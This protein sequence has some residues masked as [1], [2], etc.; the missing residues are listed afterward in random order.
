[1]TCCDC[2][3]ASYINISQIYVVFF[4]H[5]ISQL[6][7]KDTWAWKHI[8]TIRGKIKEFEEKFALA[9]KEENSKLEF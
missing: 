2:I 7:T 9:I 4:T 8:L 1:M 6:A 5:N 3:A